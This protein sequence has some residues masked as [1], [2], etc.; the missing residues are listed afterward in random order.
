[1]KV[2][3]LLA[4]LL[5]VL[6]AAVYGGTVLATPSVGLT[7][8]IY[9]KSTFDPMTLYARAMAMVPAARD[10]GMR[11]GE[12]FTQIKTLGLTDAY[13]VDN[14]I[15]P[16]GDTGWH[17]HPGPSLIFVVAGTVTNYASDDP[18]C[19]PHAYP[20]GTGFVDPGGADVHTLRNEGSVPAETIAVQFLPKDAARRIDVLTAPANCHL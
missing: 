20:A 6:G 8:T 18:G 14:K 11:P 15:A 5:G 17:S 16:L 19:T 1:M 10:G 9:A 13:V 12:W 2:R 7:T 4:L 3:W